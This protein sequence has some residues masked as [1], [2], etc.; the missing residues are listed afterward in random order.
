MSLEELLKTPKTT[1]FFLAMTCMV[2]GA[3]YLFFG[4][5]KMA[6]GV[7]VPVA[8]FMKSVAMAYILGEAGITGAKEIGSAFGSNGK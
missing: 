4:P 2:L 5:Q 3:A 8:N 1:K 7:G 6:P